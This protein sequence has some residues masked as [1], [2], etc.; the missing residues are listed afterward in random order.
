MAKAVESGER[1][2]RGASRSHRHQLDTEHRFFCY[3]QCS[4]KNGWGGDGR[5]AEQGSSRQEDPRVRRVTTIKARAQIQRRSFCTAERLDHPW[6]EEA[7]PTEA[8]MEKRI[9]GT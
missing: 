8:G 5:G 6:P 2:V 7:A 4:T 3:L 9:D 1:E